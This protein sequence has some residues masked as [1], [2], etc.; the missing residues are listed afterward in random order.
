MK[1]S[2]PVDNVWSIIVWMLVTTMYDSRT[3]K[4][5]E[6]HNYFKHIH[7]HQQSIVLLYVVNYVHLKYL[8]DWSVF[9]YL[10]QKR[11]NFTQNCYVPIKLIPHEIAVLRK[12]WFHAKLLCSSAEALTQS[13]SH[14]SW[15]VATARD[16]DGLL[17]L[18]LPR[19][20]GDRWAN[21]GLSHHRA[22]VSVN[23]D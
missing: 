16:T 20:D 17:L 15:P 7:S 10:L 18:H 21:S 3:E 23:A 12:R 1:Y 4:Q 8:L 22:L 5:T 2:Y 14:L 13:P 19:E 9:L 6:K 11:Y